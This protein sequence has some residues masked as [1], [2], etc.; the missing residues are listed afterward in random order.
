MQGR[1][2]PHFTSEENE[3][4]GKVAI[5]LANAGEEAVNALICYKLLFTRR[6]INLLEKNL[7]KEGVLEMYRMLWREA[8]VM[9]E[10]ARRAQVILQ[11]E[12]RDSASEIRR[13]DIETGFGHL[14]DEAQEMEDFNV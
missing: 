4:I 13:L 7:Y 12:G 2:R 10:A 3:E 9:D 11:M 14:N 1:E 6:V 8:Y 5:E